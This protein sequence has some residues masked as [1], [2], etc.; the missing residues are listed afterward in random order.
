MS[1]TKGQRE[2]E[3]LMET[4]EILSDKKLMVLLRQSLKEV[5][6]GKLIPWERAKQKLSR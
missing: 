5:R 3:A 1:K 6:R 2:H 4:L